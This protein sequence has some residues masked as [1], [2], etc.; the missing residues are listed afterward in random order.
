[1]CFSSKFSSDNQANNGRRSNIGKA[2]T[3]VIAAERGWKQTNNVI[4]GVY[5]FFQWEGFTVRHEDFLEFRDNGKHHFAIKNQQNL[6][7]K[8]N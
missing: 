8:K 4:E 3:L 6:F 1:M 7:P 2:V 5:S